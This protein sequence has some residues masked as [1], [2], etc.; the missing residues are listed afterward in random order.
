MDLEKKII[1]ILGASFCVLLFFRYA[2]SSDTPLALILQDE[3]QS[4]ELK[5]RKVNL[6]SVEDIEPIS[7]G[8]VQP[9]LYSGADFLADLDGQEAK[10]AF[11]GIMLPS[12]LVA[13][14]N[15]KAQRARYQELLS[16]GTWTKQDTLF[17]EQLEKDYRTTDSEIM[18]RRLNTH[19]NSIV[20]VQAAV[21][22]GWGKSRFFREA[23]NVFG[24]WSFDPK[25]DRI[26]AG[27]SRPE[28]QVYLKKYDNIAQSV[29]DYFK[30]VGR[31]G[32]Y[33]EFRINRANTD[34]YNKLLPYLDKYSE[35][36]MEYVEQLRGMIV[37]NKLSLY[38][39]FEL[40]FNEIKK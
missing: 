33:K 8:M 11:I 9:I 27:S 36:G 37:S 16:E 25:E 34:D 1:A 19:P 29:I 21:E 38:D 40:D 22:S 24:V 15:L 10:D 28:L 31:V 17:V 20:L 26:K 35:R 14:Y 3:P 30:T 7:S 23:N 39:S 2:T 12:I 32:A 4:Q 13:K 18:L 5:I 6:T